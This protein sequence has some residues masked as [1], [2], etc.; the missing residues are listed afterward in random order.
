MSCKLRSYCFVV[1]SII[2]ASFFPKTVFAVSISNQTSQTQIKWDEELLV[3]SQL[4]ISLANGTKNYLR[5]VFYKEGSSNYC[6]YTH[7]GNNWYR[8]PYDSSSAIVNLLPVTIQSSSWSGILKAKFD[9]E[10]SVCNI[11]GVYKFKIWRYNSSGNPSSSDIQNELTM[12]VIF[13]TPTP[14]EKPN[15]TNAPTPSTTLTPIPTDIPKAVYKINKAKDN[16]GVELSSVKI[17]VDDVYTHHYDNEVLTFCDG[18]HC[19]D[20]DAIDCGFGQHTVRLEKGG[21][22]DWQD[23]RTFNSGDSD[24]TVDP[25]LAIIVPSSTATLIPTSTPT[26]TPTPKTSLTPTKTPTPSLS[27]TATP[28]GEVLGE[29]AASESGTFHLTGGGMNLEGSVDNA[30][31]ETSPSWENKR[32]LILPG[33]AAVVGMGFIGFSIFSFLKSR[34]QRVV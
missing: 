9:L 11:P 26:P 3:N 17:Y 16:N 14:T 33:V 13:P 6:G 8:G 22:Q 31:K 5:G 30:G 12:E 23:T 2:F 32:N 7:N 15:P 25:V 1:F 10:D 21:Y 24:V 18:C 29:E 34:R 20:E 28:S 4:N 27:L 19:D